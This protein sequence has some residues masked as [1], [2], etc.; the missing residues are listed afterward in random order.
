M[1]EAVE[2]AGLRTKNAKHFRK[3]DGTRMGVF[4]VGS[5]HYQAQ[6]D[7]PL[8]DKK[9]SFRVGPGTAEWISDESDVTMRTYQVGQGGNRRW[10]VE[11]KETL[12]G[13][14]VAFELQVQPTTTA[15][16]NQ[17]DFS[18]GQGGTWSYFHTRAGG[19]MLGPPTPASVGTRTHT[20][21]YSLIGGA[22]PL[23][24]QN[25]ELA[26]GNIFRMARP[27]LVGADGNRYA[28][29]NWGHDAAAGTISFGYSDVGLPAAAYP[30]RVDPSTTFAITAGAND[31]SNYAS[32][33]TANGWP[34]SGFGSI[35]TTNFSNT[36]CIR[37][38]LNASN[39]QV[40]NFPMQ[41]D[42]SSIRAYATVIGA[43]VELYAISRSNTNSVNM[44]FGWF[45]NYTGTA[46]DWTITPESNALGNTAIST[47]TLTAVNTYTLLNAAANVNKTGNTG[48][49][50]HIADLGSAPTGRNLVEWAQFEHATAQEARLIVDYTVTYDETVRPTSVALVTGLTPTDSAS[51]TAII[52]EDPGVGTD[53]LVGTDPSGITG[54][55][56]GPDYP[57]A[58]TGATGL[59][60]FA[61]NGAPANAIDTSDTTFATELSNNTALGDY[62]SFPAAAFSA[63]PSN[64][65][66]TN[67][68]VDTKHRAGTA[69]RV[70]IFE[71]LGTVN[72]TL[73]GTEL[74]VNG[75]GNTIPNTAGGATHTLNFTTSL[76]TRAQLVTGTFGVR[77][78][79]T[80]SN[81][82]TYELYSIK[83]TVTY[84][85]P[86]STTNTEVRAAMGDPTSTLET[87]AASGEIQVQ[88]RKLGSGSTPQVRAEIREGGTLKATPIAN[89]NVTDTDA[90]GQVITGNFD[91]SNIS[92]KNSVEVWIVGTGAA[93]GLVEVGSTEWN[94][95]AQS[96]GT[97]HQKSPIDTAGITDVATAARLKLQAPI[98]AAALADTVVSARAISR[99][100]V[101]GAGVLD[102]TSGYGPD[103]WLDEDGILWGDTAQLPWLTRD[104]NHQGLIDTDLAAGRAYLDTDGALYI[105]TVEGGGVPQSRTV[106]DGAGISDVL[107]TSKG[108]AR[109]AVDSAALS[110]S[111]VPARAL[112]RSVSDV[113]AA[114][115]SALLAR[116]LLRSLTDVAGAQDVLASTRGLG[117]SVADVAAA[118]DS[119]Q[120]FRALARSVLDGAGAADLASPVRAISRSIA[121]VAAL[122]DVVDRQQAGV[123]SRAVIDGAG[124]TDTVARTLVVAR[125]VLDG[126]GL[127]DVSSRSVA[128]SRT[129]IET[130][131]VTDLPTRALA[132]SRSQVD[133]A[134][135]VDMKISDLR[136]VI[137]RAVADGAGLADVLARTRAHG[138]TVTDTTAVGDVL[139]RQMAYAR[140]LVELAGVLD[141]VNRGGFV[142]QRSVIDS[143]ALVDLATRLLL[144][145]ASGGQDYRPGR[146]GYRFGGGGRIQRYGTGGRIKS[147]SGGG[148]GF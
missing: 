57:D 134:G 53:F 116:A 4:S 114:T 1:A 104:A 145:A 65:T 11:F 41:F 101:D 91:Q 125:A 34:P 118:T 117:R 133:A 67:V 30:Y 19:K 48:L 33:P 5:I 138:R 51:A 7:G 129:Q 76:P 119:A 93:G 24:L 20:F 59:T 94:I 70:S 56:D 132:L 136:R 96:S 54:A 103:L 113:G 82:S 120:P 72:G 139:V 43:Q 109:S 44:C 107:A 26:C 144:N 147:G 2:L 100:V 36:Y 22:P 105:N 140:A 106:T 84:D 83:V 9:E 52:D 112:A 77:L 135:V 141:E 123:I 3:P 40:G 74:Q 27:H 14:G 79:M 25:G 61:W 87:G 45:P 95:K 115:D 71:Q 102:S 126:A 58:R 122:L 50:V 29:A 13:M 47:I 18:D 16:S 143:A 63:I 111:A 46:A 99:T 124:G 21:R 73:L 89:T 97:Q 66:I 23:T 88:A 128:Y 142:I 75:T 148:V 130:A 38:L 60:T 49:R 146:G 78:R 8:L 17:L 98:D 85:V 127:L 6:P 15:G 10:W 64:A 55:T 121:D 42:T 110:D 69:N 35:T 68:Q 28:E 131:L 86:G 62:F 90:D 137:E 37:E 39:Y 92:N 108:V 81:T 31:S 80:R 32:A 12:T